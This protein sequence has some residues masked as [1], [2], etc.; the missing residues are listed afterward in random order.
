MNFFAKKANQIISIREHTFRRFAAWARGEAYQWWLVPNCVDKQKFFPA[1]K[2]PILVERYGIEGK[3]VIITAGRL[4]DDSNERYKGFDETLEVLPW[5]RKQIPNVI[6]LIMGDGPDRFR[7]AGKARM[8]GVEDIVRFTG[9]IAEN[10]KA[11][12]Y[13][14]ADVFSM[15]GSNPVFDRY[16]LRM[17]FLEALACGIPVVA[18]RA[19]GPGESEST[20]AR[21]LIQVDPEDAVDTCA[22]IV[23]AIARPKGIVPTRLS[24]YLYQP[25][26]ARVHAI[27]DSLKILARR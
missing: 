19:D 7:L 24:E 9:R 20:E 11:D 27:V 26:R 22:G 21:T 3:T 18:S 4:A 1:P 10:E 12:H 16:P 6:Y 2:N 23:S 8:C 14:L 25:F 17:V 13:R 5:L 15:P